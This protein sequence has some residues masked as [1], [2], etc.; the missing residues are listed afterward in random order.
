MTVVPPSG[1]APTPAI[2]VTPTDRPADLAV[3]SV[4]PWTRLLLAVIAFLVLP[5]Q[6]RSMI[7]VE[8]TI[9]L[10]V[11]TLAALSLVGWWAGG[12]VHLAVIWVGMATY[13]TVSMGRAATSFDTL[14]AA[15]GLLL[16][17]TFGMLCLLSD[18]RAFFA[19]ALGAVATALGLGF[20]ISAFGPASFAQSA[21]TI[22]QEFGR[23]NQEILAA[24]SKFI[25]DYPLQWKQFTASLPATADPLGQ[26]GQMFADL[27]HAGM[28]AFPA[29]LALESLAAL[30][31]A[32]SAYHRLAR[33]RLGPPLAALRDFR[34]NDQLVWG[35]IVGLILLLLPTLPAWR[36][37]G[38]NL[39]VFF[40][41]LYALR[42]AGVLVWFLSL[43]ALLTALGLGFVA[44]WVPF[45]RELAVLG[46][47]GLA[48]AIVGLGLGDTWADW[49]TRAQAA[50]PPAA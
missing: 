21:S 15:W 9:V 23:R 37:V 7:P 32:W 46:F 49:R 18:R 12:R 20:A 36:G 38:L 44:L 26:V 39:V 16:A 24:L 48:I 2:I 1:E 31:L 29:L 17:G 3:P 27:S 30:A 8:R 33:I 50:R 5:T 45:L 25:A 41:V 42:G 14:A 34:F 43:S 35:L 28:S 40:A 19:R 10:L 6:L 13:L 22:S 47:I 11:P 4:R